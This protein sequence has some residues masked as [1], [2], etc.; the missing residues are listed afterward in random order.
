MD[1]CGT[2][3]NR[4]KAIELLVKC[5]FYFSH[6]VG[7]TRLTKLHNSWIRDMVFGKDY[8]TLQAHRG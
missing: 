7:F 2:L 1:I 4:E 5:P 8:V 6:A 3:L